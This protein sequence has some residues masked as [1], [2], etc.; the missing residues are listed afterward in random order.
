MSQTIAKKPATDADPRSVI[1][2]PGRLSFPVL[3]APEQDD[4]GNDRYSGTLLLPPDY[5]IKPLLN[6]LNAACIAGWGE[7]KR[8]WPQG[9]TVRLPQ[10]VIRDA[11]T[12]S[13]NGYEPGWHFVAF[14]GKNRPGIID[15]LK[16][17]VT[18]PS[19]AYPGR[20]ARV[21]LR[22]FT[23]KNKKT[24]VSFGLNNVQL[25]RH[26]ERLGGAPRAESEFDEVVDQMTNDDF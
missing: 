4:S 26:D 5:D 15:G 23:F 19:E 3:F 2:G 21:S 22:A 10:D 9:L 13:Y 18:D 24:G 1:A 6:A 17:R 16:Q 8:K 25:L 12:K 14:S 7:D 11:G 20:W